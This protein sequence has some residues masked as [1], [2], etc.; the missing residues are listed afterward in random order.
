[1]VVRVDG[2]VVVRVGGQR[3]RNRGVEHIAYPVQ[4]WKASFEENKE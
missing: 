1:M 4:A 2:H 3:A